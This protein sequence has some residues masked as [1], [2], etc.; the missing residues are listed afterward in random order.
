MPG[1]QW[2][3]ILP[4]TLLLLAGLRLPLSLAVPAS[5]R[6][7]PRIKPRVKDFVGSHSLLEH[8]VLVFKNVSEKLSVNQYMFLGRM[9]LR[10]WQPSRARR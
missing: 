10:G 8:L 7:F 6:G 4:E 3:F 5:T 1:G 2:S 9:K